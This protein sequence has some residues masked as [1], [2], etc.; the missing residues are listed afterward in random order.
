MAR[1]EKW[2]DKFIEQAE[3]ACKFGATDHEVAEVLG[4]CV[5]T[6]NYWRVSRPEFA[7]ALKA[8]KDVA[9]ERVERSLYQKATGYDYV[10]QQAIKLKVEKDQ[11]K[12]EVV[13]VQKHAPAETVAAIFWLKN[14]RKAEW[15]DR[16]E[17]EHSGSIDVGAELSERLAA[18]RKKAAEEG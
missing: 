5:R 6:I 15:R 8:G 14:R 13:D 17:V 10:E 11:E 1:P 2:D 7:A 18:A 9:D 3:I 12:V 4:V 16:Q